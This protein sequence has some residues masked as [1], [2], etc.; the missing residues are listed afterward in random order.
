[1]FPLSK[2]SE[3]LVKALITMKC[4]ERLQ[5]HQIQG[6]DYD[7]IFPTIQWLVRKVIE[8]RRL[9]GDLVRQLSVNQFA[10]RG[11]EFAD[12]ALPEEAKTMIEEVRSTYG[13]NRVFR[14]RQQ[15]S[16]QSSVINVVPFF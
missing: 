12:L 4:P 15:A 2:L 10:K 5:S 8:H 14:K 9:T 6:L 16:F 3:N 7:H 11:Y 1:M 13:P